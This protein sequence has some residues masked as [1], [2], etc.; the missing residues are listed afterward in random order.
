[1]KCQARIVREYKTKK[2]DVV[3]PECLGGPVPEHLVHP[4]CGGDVKADVCVPYSGCAC[5]GDSPEVKVE[6]TCSR[7]KNPYIPGCLDFPYRSDEFLRK[8]VQRYIDEE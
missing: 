5:C 6:L 1:M 8:L 7:C 3:W 4:V 2:A